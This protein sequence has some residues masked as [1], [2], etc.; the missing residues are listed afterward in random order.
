MPRKKWFCI[1]VGATI[2]ITEA[3]S[4][5]EAETNAAKARF[6]H[7]TIYGESIGI[8]I[9]LEELLKAIQSALRMKPE[10]EESNEDSLDRE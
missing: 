10:V 3:S 9:E 5:M 4:R 2:G 1:A 6:R 7:G 8:C